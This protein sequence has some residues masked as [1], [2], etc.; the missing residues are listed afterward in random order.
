MELK[1]KRAILFTGLVRDEPRF[2]RFIAD[3]AALPVEARCP[4]YFSTWIGEVQKYPAVKQALT[5]CGAVILEQPEPDVVLPGHALHQMVSLDLGL[6]VIGPDVFVYK[7]RPDFA[8]FD[9]FRKYLGQVARPVRQGGL[10]FPGQRHRFHVLAFFASQPMY[11]NDIVFAGDS[12]DLRHLSA[13]SLASSFRY[14][15]VAP[16]QIIWGGAFIPLVP[17]LDAF[18]RANIGLIFGNRELFEASRDVLVAS[19]LY[20]RALASYFELL[21]CS[22]DRLDPDYPAL[23]VSV[24]GLTLDQMLWEPLPDNRC[25]GHHVQAHVNTVHAVDVADVLMAGGFV[26][27]PLGNR[28]IAELRQLRSGAAEGASYLDEALELGRASVQSGIHG[29]KLPTPYE[30][31]QRLHGARAEWRPLGERTDRVVEL[32]TQINHMRRTIESLMAQVKEKS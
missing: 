18:F 27:S 15:R 31:A 3:Y 22:F 1:L 23:D 10:S 8:S 13:W 21:S 16:E 29:F 32:E 14:L 6:S 2:L 5:E 17:S 19:P 4:F 26:E 12:S 25:L 20:A 24:S 7:S 11:I 30:G 28:V 9:S